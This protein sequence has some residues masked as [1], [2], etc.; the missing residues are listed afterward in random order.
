MLTLVRSEKL[1]YTL[2]DA[3]DIDSPELGPPPTANF[4]ER[5]PIK[6]DPLGKLTD[7]KGA[8]LHDSN[9]QNPCNASHETRRKRRE[10]S[11]HMESGPP[12][13]SDGFQYERVQSGDASP[14]QAQT[15]KAG[16]AKRK[17]TS[18][19]NDEVNEEPEALEQED[20]I[21]HRRKVDSKAMENGVEVEDCSS[22]DPR[23][24]GLPELQAKK[25]HNTSSRPEKTRHS[26]LSSVSKARRALGPSM[27]TKPLKCLSH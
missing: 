5:N 7:D 3:D 24:A 11:H 12:N 15:L 26:A 20:P 4:D 9:F 8:F 19:E 27:S 13:S 18:R 16:G 21:L 1:L 10:S 23:M 6:Y 17:F 22:R 14:V 25:N 2:E